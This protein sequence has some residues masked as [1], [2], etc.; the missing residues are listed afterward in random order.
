M[1]YKLFSSRLTQQ[2]NNTVTLDLS[3]NALYVVSQLMWDKH[4]LPFAA[5][6][7]ESLAKKLVTTQTIDTVC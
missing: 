7:S 5:A 2:C 3:P 4:R 1:Y 6:A